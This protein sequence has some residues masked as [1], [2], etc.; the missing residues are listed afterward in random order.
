MVNYCL[1][2]QTTNILSNINATNCKE[3][4]LLSSFCPMFISGHRSGHPALGGPAGVR[5]WTG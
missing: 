4:H 1:K 5:C 2:F 3:M